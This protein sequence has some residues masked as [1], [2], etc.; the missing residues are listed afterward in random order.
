MKGFD[1]EEW[2][3]AAKD[4][5]QSALQQLLL[6]N[7]DRLAEHISKRIPDA[8]RPELDVEDILQMTFIEVFRSFSD[9]QARDTDA[10]FAWLRA[11]ANA[12]AADVIRRARRKKRGGDWKRREGHVPGSQES[13]L[14]LIDLVSGQER[15]PSRMAAA[16]EAIAAL[17]VALA[18]LPED[19]GEA[20][21][22]RYLENLNTEKVEEKMGLSNGAV[23]GLLHRGKK[24][25]RKLLGNP[26]AWFSRTP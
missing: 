15:S 16:N 23:R 3:A 2:L 26:S 13:Y 10:F 17:Q 22:L 6:E 20:I 18:S 8:V 19:Q 25:L 24:S 1:K 11:V 9:F 7:F 14:R 21:R 5:D 4:G 12:R